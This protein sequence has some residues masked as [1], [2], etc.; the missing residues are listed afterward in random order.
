MKNRALSILVAFALMLTVVSGVSLAG[1][2]EKTKLSIILITGYEF[3]QEEIARYEAEHPEVEVDVQIM[4]TTDYK[5]LIKTK[6]ASNDA[7][8][9]LPVFCEA[10]YYAFY[11]NGYL[12]DISDMAGT[13]GRLKE[14]ASNSF[15]TKDGGMMGIPYTQ[16]FLLGYYNK[17]MF[18]EHGLEVPNTWEELLAVCEAFKASGITPAA[19]GHKD[20]W[21]ALMIP[22]GLNATS[23]QFA[24]PAFYKGTADGTS[25]FAESAGWLD[26]LSKYRGL[27][28]KGYANEGSLS[29]TAEQ[30]YELFV[31]HKAA[32]FF[33]GTW[34]DASVA[35]LNPD[36]TVGGFQ[37]P[38][39]GGSKGASVSI[40]GGF[41]VN[42]GSK[43]LGAAKELLTYML[44]KDALNEYGSGVASCFKDVE[45]AISPALQEAL[46][47]MAGQP[48]YQYDDTY[49]VSGLQ[50]VMCASIQEMIAG[51][52]TPMQVLEAM[53]AATAK[54]NR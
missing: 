48:C 38:A 50:A 18:E 41:G 4:P 22:Y 49:F 29:T 15:I 6:L 31:N 9:I 28:D 46:D 3:F 21:V 47:D 19:F 53:D 34:C 54:A 8:D 17:Q 36:F 27:I 52:K 11:D 7:P 23:V 26:T 51:T 40:S 2:A 45:T 13:I 12:A 43:N 1:N 32:M 33:G 16:E 30:M 24:D 44:G 35:A 20:A 42:A 25:K 14:G 5:T 37:I 10:D 39:A